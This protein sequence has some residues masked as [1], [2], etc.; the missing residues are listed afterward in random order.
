[1]VEHLECDG[2]PST[3]ILS[4]LSVAIYSY[5]YLMDALLFIAR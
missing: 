3:G 5:P 1:M 4:L 2:L